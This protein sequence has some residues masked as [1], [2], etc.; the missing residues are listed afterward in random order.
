MSAFLQKHVG[1][2][3]DLYELT[4]AQAYGLT[5]QAH[6]AACFDYFFRETPFKNGYVIFAGLDDLLGSLEALRFEKDDLDYLA[7]LGFQ[8]S[9]LGF[10]KDFRFKGKIFS[11][12]EGEV[13]FPLEPVLRV[14]GT[15]LECQLLETLLLN[16]LN[17]QSLIATKAARM[18]QA[19]QSRRVVEFGL[20]RSQG[21]AGLAASRAAAIGGVESTSNVHASFLYGLTPAGT[22]AHSW[23]QSFPDELTAFRKYAQIYPERCTLLV[24]TYNTLK[25]GVPHAI[26]VAKE[27]ELQGHRLSAIRLDSGDLAY[28]SK[29][30]RVLLDQASLHY[31]KIVVSNQLDEFIIK[32]LLDQG[33]P[34]NAFGVGTNLV[35]GQQN[36]SLDG[37]YKLNWLEGEP[38]LKISENVTKTSLPGVKKIVRYTDP[39]GF[40]YAD[41]VLLEDEKS[42]EYIH[43]PHFPE[44]KSRVAHCFPES[45]LFKVME[46]GR[47]LVSLGVA[48]AAAYAKQRL[49]KLSPERKR[50]ENPHIYKVGMSQKL[51]EMRA[52]LIQKYQEPKP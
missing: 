2:Y 24:D 4:M 47:R 30:A 25:S 6:K 33:A 49:A 9:F 18:V 41:G 42:A 52:Q 27:M 15:L 7:S 44:Q 5:G 51:M 46:D 38:R 12:R 23:I 48:E 50:F 19:A 21:L 28:L 16:Q 35:T 34:I 3:T 29:R 36:P 40:F 43:H 32:S 37:V 10:L 45:I 13:I 17:F 14:E 26:Q 39:E 31:V 1:L 11:V 22:Q 20:R 8:E